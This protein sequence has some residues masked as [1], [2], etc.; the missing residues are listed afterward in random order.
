MPNWQQRGFRSLRANQF[1][2][3]KG[4][5]LEGLVGTSQF[6][7]NLLIAR[8]RIKADEPN[9]GAAL[10]LLNEKERA[11]IRVGVSVAI[12]TR[13][14]NVPSLMSAR[15]YADQHSGASLAKK[16]DYAT[17][18][19]TTYR[20]QALGRV[21]FRPLPNLKTVFIDCPNVCTAFSAI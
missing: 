16:D 2:I 14:W 4:K 6:E 12:K 1:V 8:F 19:I 18:A 11:V 15:I 17:E 13:G 7:R 5:V 9:L 3:A 20:A 10:L 21:V